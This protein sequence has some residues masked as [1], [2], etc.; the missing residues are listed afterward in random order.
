[1]ILL[2][3]NLLM[4]SGGFFFRQIKSNINQSSRNQCQRKSNNSFGINIGK[5]NHFFILLRNLI[6]IYKQSIASM[7]S[8][9]KNASLLKNEPWN[10]DNIATAATIQPADKFIKRS[11]TLTRVTLSIYSSYHILMT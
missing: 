8:P 11:A 9:V 6:A 1:M 2:T 4:D 3:L 7:I 5:I 10:E